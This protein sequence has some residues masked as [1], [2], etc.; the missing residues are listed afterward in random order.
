[1]GRQ[2]SHLAPALGVPDADGP[3]VAGRREGFTARRECDP[4]QA[5]ALTRLGGLYGLAAGCLPKS[6]RAVAARG[7]HESF[8]RM[9]GHAG[10]GLGMS[11]KRLQG[12][13]A[14]D[15]PNPDRIVVAA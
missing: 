7:D 8:S 11:Q 14:V 4:I 10:N 13:A 2:V 15:R 5:A 1:M 12:A 3:I 9:K 6:P